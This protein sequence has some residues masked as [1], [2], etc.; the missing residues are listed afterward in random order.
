MRINVAEEEIKKKIVRMIWRPITPEYI[1]KL[2]NSIPQQMAALIQPK[3]ART[4]YSW[5]CN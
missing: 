4:N 2:Y 1:E 3:G 5:I